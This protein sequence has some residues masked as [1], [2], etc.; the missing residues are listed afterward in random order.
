M[1]A[2]CGCFARSRDRPTAAGGEDVMR[3]AARRDSLAPDHALCV[4]WGRLSRGATISR[5]RSMMEH[6]EQNSGPARVSLARPANEVGLA[7]HFP[8]LRLLVTPFL[9]FSGGLLVSYVV[10]NM[11]TSARGRWWS[12]MFAWN[13]G[14]WRRFPIPFGSDAFL[15][16][17]GS[18]IRSKSEWLLLVVLPFVFVV[19]FLLVLHW[20]L[21]RVVYSVYRK[22]GW[23]RYLDDV[24]ERLSL[25]GVWK[26]TILQSW[27]VLP[28]FFIL[29][30]IWSWYASG[31][32]YALYQS[33][34][35]YWHIELA[36]L[37]IAIVAYLRIMSRRIVS[38]VKSAVREADC[39]CNRCGY[40]L[41]GLTSTACPECGDEFLFEIPPRFSLLRRE[42]IRLRL[43]SRIL[44]VALVLSVASSP[45]WLPKIINAMPRQIAL[46]LP[47]S[48]LQ[49][50]IPQNA[51]P[52]VKPGTYCILQRDREFAVFRIPA[53]RKK[54]IRFGYW[55]NADH[56][57]SMRPDEIGMFSLEDSALE[58]HSLGDNQFTV[59]QTRW[60]FNWWLYIYPQETGWEFEVVPVD[61][62]PLQLKE[63][64]AWIEGDATQ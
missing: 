55:G 46:H 39:R 32:S 48:I 53:E 64:F 27:W 17:S 52:P 56:W 11:L 30:G 23:P 9:V 7:R 63:L 31:Q 26:S 5:A 34:Y 45:A 19:L 24:G 28:C 49:H 13:T 57:T 44:W 2:T 35:W 62:A 50:R 18:F 10:S 60:Q 37:A 21:Y 36:F 29:S 8:L 59:W 40:M 14:P 61:S 3:R 25:V 1:E 54:P 47:R 6:S 16:G 15:D 41:R 42:A 33:I 20:F 58:S 12:V 38:A 43:A 22:A 4:F 51:V